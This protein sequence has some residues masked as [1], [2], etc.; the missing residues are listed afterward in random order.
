V[1]LPSKKNEENIKGW[2]N[3]RKLAFMCFGDLK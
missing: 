1:V 2:E 3:G